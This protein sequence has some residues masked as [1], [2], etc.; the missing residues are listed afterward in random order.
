M[1]EMVG[2]A[3]PGIV[4]IGLYGRLTLPGGIEIYLTGEELEIAKK[5]K[6]EAVMDTDGYMRVSA[7]NKVH[8]AVNSDGNLEVSTKDMASTVTVKVSPSLEGVHDP[9]KAYDR[10]SVVYDETTNVSYISRTDVP[11]G[12]NLTNANYWQPY[13]V[14]AQPYITDSVTGAVYTIQMANGEVMAKQMT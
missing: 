1:Y 12:I 10:L 8:L 2:G 13:S 14:Q 4:G 11:A 3:C 7:S 5:A 6:L 9:T